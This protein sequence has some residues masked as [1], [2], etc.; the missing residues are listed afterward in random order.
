MIAIDFG[1]DLLTDKKY[2]ELKFKLSSYLKKFLRNE[3]D[4]ED[5]VQTTFARLIEKQYIKNPEPVVGRLAFTI[6]RNAAIDNLRRYKRNIS[7]MNKLS[8]K[9]RPFYFDKD[10]LFRE[11]LY[12]ALD[13]ISYIQKSILILRFRNGM[14]FKEI[15]EQLGIPIN[16]VKVYAMRGLLHLK[17]I[18]RRESLQLMIEPQE[19]KA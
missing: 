7:L 2:D 15:S 14:T 3:Q 6:A 4:I 1:S 5:M 17:K 18:I 9:E 16:S 8:F 11:M 19:I 10:V 12:S 13:R